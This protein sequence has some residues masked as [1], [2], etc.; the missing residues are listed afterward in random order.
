MAGQRLLPV[1]H[2]LLGLLGGDDLEELLDSIGGGLVLE[3][4]DDASQGVAD[5]RIAVQLQLLVGLGAAVDG[6]KVDAVDAQGG[7]GVINDLLPLGK[8]AVA[9]G[10]VREVDGVL[11]AKDSL[12][13]EVD[14]V[15]VRLVAVGLVSGALQAIRILVAL[16]GGEFCDGGLVD[17]GQVLFRLDGGGFGGA[18]FLGLG[19]GL[20]WLL[21]RLGS[22]PLGLL[23]L[24]PLLLRRTG[25]FGL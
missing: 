13:V 7:G 16:L 17:G 21:L 6:L 2:A 24:S 18:L 10:T 12:G 8:G 25:R 3:V 4:V 5:K 23:P 11:L 1:L 22:F 14:G 9:R 20:G 19:V 15:V